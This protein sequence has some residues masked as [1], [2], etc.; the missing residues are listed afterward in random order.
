MSQLAVK[1]YAQQQL[2]LLDVPVQ[3]AVFSQRPKQVAVG[4]QAVVVITCP[5]SR[6]RRLTV[7][8]GSGR[9]EVVHRLRLEVYWVA[10]DEQTG[11]RAFDTLLWQ[12]DNLFRS[13]AIP[14]AVSDPESGEASVVLFIGEAIETTLHEP[15]LDEAPQ[16]LVA[17]SAEKVLTVTEHVTG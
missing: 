6:E 14:A 2:A 16:G 13:V 15:V 11:G 8:R 7:T 4:D 9:K 17:F 1:L 12:L 3:A 10:A 5:E